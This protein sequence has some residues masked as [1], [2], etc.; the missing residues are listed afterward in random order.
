M[1]GEA[2]DL[3]IKMNY[4]DV[5]EWRRSGAG[6]AVRFARIGRMA[7]AMTTSSALALMSMASGAWAQTV[8]PAIT[9]DGRTQTQIATTTTPGGS[10]IDITTGTVTGAYGV[11]AF[12]SFG[13]AAGQ[14]V[15]MHIPTGAAGTVN[16]VTGGQSAIHGALSSV[17]PGG[18][19]GGEMYFANSSGFLIGP[20]GQVQAGTVGLSTAS[21]AYIDA[22][23]GGSGGGATG[24]GISGSH[25]EALARGEAPL[26]GADIEVQ[27]QVAGQSA[28]RMRAGGDITISGQVSAGSRTSRMAAAV[29]TGVDLQSGGT[30]TISGALTAQNGDDG[31]HIDIRPT[32]D[33]HVT[34]GAVIL[35][36]GE[37]AGHGGE[38]TIFASGAARLDAGA[39]ISAAAAGSGDGGFVEFSATD[40]VSIAGDLQAYSAGGGAGGSI[41]IDPEIVEVI[42]ADFFSLGANIDIL[43]T[44]RITIDPGVT[45]SS[46]ATLPGAGAFADSV[47]HSGNITLTA[48]VVELGAGSML[49]SFANG[50]DASGNP[51]RSGDITLTAIEDD[52]V[53]PQAALNPIGRTGI[54][55]LDATI[56]GGNVTLTATTNKQRTATTAGGVTAYA[57]DVTDSAG[58]SFIDSYIADQVAALENGVQTVLS[59]DEIANAPWA[60]SAQASILLSDTLIFADGTVSIAASAATDMRIAPDT[61]QVNLAFAVTDTQAEVFLQDSAIVAGGAVDVTARTSE[62]VTLRAEAGGNAGQSNTAAAVSYRNARAEVLAQGYWSD[63]SGSLPSAID[64]FYSVIEAG[65]KI[66]IAA[67][68]T[69]DITLEAYSQTNDAGVGNALTFSREISDADVHLGGGYLTDEKALN[70]SATTTYDQFKSVAVT[71]G[72]AGG[73]LPDAFDPTGADTIGVALD[74][75]RDVLSTALGFG[76]VLDAFPVASASTIEWHDV[77]ST[78]VWGDNQYQYLDPHQDVLR[79]LGSAYHNAFDWNSTTSGTSAATFTAETVIDTLQVAAL[80]QLEA[81]ES[82]AGLSSFGYSDWDIDTLAMFGSGSSI[83]ERVDLTLQAHT[84]LPEFDETAID[85]AGDAVLEAAD[86]GTDLALL[87]ASVASPSVATLVGEDWHFLTDLT[88][89]AGRGALALDFAERHID[90]TTT[91][92]MGYEAYPGGN[93][94]ESYTVAALTDGA[95]LSKRGNSAAWADYTTGENHGAG[96]AYSNLDVSAQT[97]ASIEDVNGEMLSVTRARD[98]TLSAKNRLTLSNQVSSY[99][100]ADGS[101]FAGAYAR[102]HYDGLAIAQFDEDNKP[103]FDTFTIRALDDTNLLAATQAGQMAGGVAG[104]GLAWTRVSQ[105]REVAAEITELPDGWGGYASQGAMTRALSMDAD[106]EGL[107]L[108]SADSGAKASDSAGDAGGGA[109]LP[110]FAGEDDGTADTGGEGALSGMGFSITG[111]GD[112]AGISDD[113]T[114]RVTA[115]AE[116]GWAVTTGQFTA[117]NRSVLMTT[118]GAAASGAGLIGLAGGYSSVASTRSTSVALSGGWMGLPGSLVSSSMSIAASDSAVL[119]ALASGRG[120]EGPEFTGIGSV[121]RLVNTAVTSAHGTGGT[122][123]ETYDVTATRAGAAIALAGAYDATGDAEAPDEDGATA[124]EEA[125]KGSGVGLSYTTITSA[126]VTSASATTTGAPD[127]LSIAARNDGYTAGFAFSETAGGA[128][129][130]AGAGM[131]IN[132]TQ[133]TLATGSGIAGASTEIAARNTARV[134]SHI[135]AEGEAERA[136]GGGAIAILNDT[137]DTEAGAASLFG[138]AGDAIT[139]TARATGTS[140]QYLRAGA[141]ADGGLAGELSVARLHADWR[142]AAIGTAVSGAAD[143]LDISAQEAG[144]LENRQGGMV[145][146]EGGAG[147]IGWSETL[148]ESDVAAS[149]SGADIAADTVDVAALS[150]SEITTKAV[151]SGDAKAGGSGVVALSKYLGST[152][153]EVAGGAITADA[154]TVTAHD[155]TWRE[156]VANAAATAETVGAA[157]AIGAD[158]YQR[159][160]SA[161]ISSSQLTLGDDGLTLAATSDTRAAMVSLGRVMDGGQIGFAGVVT[162]LKDDRDVRATLSGGSLATTGGLDVTASRNDMALMLQGT[163]ASST[164]GAG[165][166]A[167]FASFGGRTEARVDQPDVL[168]IAGDFN[169]FAGNGTQ[170]ISLGFGLGSATTGG[171]IGSFADLDM[172]HLANDAAISD[173]SER[174]DYARE[175]AG[176]AKGDIALTLATAGSEAGS[177]AA[178]N[179]FDASGAV[180]LAEADLTGTTATIGV[181]MDIHAYDGR[182]G[183]AIAGQFQAGYLGQNIAAVDKVFDVDELNATGFELT[184]RGSELADESAPEDSAGVDTDGTESEGL[185]DYAEATEDEADPSVTGGGTGGLT[186]GASVAWTRVGGEVAASL[187]MGTVAG[188]GTLDVTGDLDVRTTTAA[189]AGAFSFGAQSSDAALGAGGAFARQ[190]QLATAEISG[191]VITAEDVRVEAINT[192][193]ATTIAGLATKG[194]SAAFGAVLTV[195]D[196]DAET[197]AAIDGATIT[198]G[199]LE[200]EARDVSRGLS[201]GLAGGGAS[202]TAVNMSIAAMSSRAVVGASVHGGAEIDA[203][204]LQIRAERDQAVNALLVQATG[205][206]NIAAGAT[207][208]SVKLAGANEA[209]LADAA[210]DVADDARVLAETAGEI[211]ALSIGAAVGGSGGVSGSLALVAKEDATLAEIADSTVVAGDAVLVQA[212]NTGLIGGLAGGD[213][214]LFGLLSGGQLNLAGGSSFGIGVSVG[215]TKSASQTIARIS[216]DS[217]ITAAATGSGV[218][219]AVRYDSSGYDDRTERT[220]DGIAVIADNDSAIDILAVSAAAGSVAATVQ[221]PVVITEDVVTAEVDGGAGRAALASE[222]EINVFAANDTALSLTSLVAAAAGSGAGGADIEA[223][224]LSKQTT[225]AIR[226]ADVDGGDDIAVTAVAPDQMTTLSGALAAGGGAGVSGIV[227]VARSTSRTEALAQD[228]DLVADNDIS[229]LAKA[230]RSLHQTALN[231]AFGGSAGVGAA[232]LVLSAEDY[233]RAEALDGTIGANVLFDAAEA[234]SIEAESV[235]TATSFV[236]A[237][238]IGGAAGISGSILVADFDQTVIARAG[239]RASSGAR[240]GSLAINATQRID[241]TATVGNVAGGTVGI[242]AS[243]LAVSGS[244]TVLAG[245]GDHTDFETR[246]AATIAASGVRDFAGVSVAAGGGAFSLQGSVTSLAFGMDGESEQSGEHMA[247]LNGD[248]ASGE[249]YEVDGHSVSNGDGEFDGIL[250]QT[251]AM[252]AASID[253]GLRSDE[254]RAHLGEDA[255]LVA[256]TDLSVSATEEG[257]QFAISGAAGGGIVSITGGVTHVRAGTTVGVEIEDGA[258]LDAGGLFE[259][260]IEITGRSDVNLGSTDARGKL[261]DPNGDYDGLTGPTAFAASGGLVG[262]AGAVVDVRAERSVDVSIGDGAL[263]GGAETDIDIRAEELGDIKTTAVSAAGGFVAIGGTFAT[264]KNSSAVKIALSD[265]VL[266]GDAVNV[267]IA[268]TGAVRATAVGVTGG[269]VGTSAVDVAAHDASLAQIDLGSAFISATDLTVRASTDANVVAIGTGVSVGLGAIGAVFSNVDREARAEVMGNGVL[270]LADTVDILAIDAASEAAGDGALIK[271]KTVSTAGGGI[272]VGGASSVLDNRSV[273]QLDLIFDGLVAD[274]AA[275]RAVT[276]ST[277]DAISTGVTLGSVAGG[278]NLVDVTSASTANTLVTFDN[279]NGQSDASG[280]GGGAVIAGDLTVAA[281]GQSEIEMDTRSGTGG[282]FTAQAAYAGLSMTP[283]T[284]VALTGPDAVTVGETARIGAERVISFAN[285]GDSLQATLAG[286]GATWLHN[287]IE[288][289]IDA[290]LDAPLEAAQVE[291]TALTEIEKTED[292][293]SGQIGAVGLATANGLWSDTEITNDA[294]I[295]IN[296]GAAILQG[297]VAPDP[298][299]PGVLIAITNVYDIADSV[300]IDTGGGVAVPAALSHVSIDTVASEIEF[301]GGDV[302]ADGDIEAR[303]S[304]FVDVAN[305][306]YVNVYGLAGV[307]YAEAISEYEGAQVID[308]NNGSHL[309]SSTGDVRLGAGDNA[310]AL[311]SE[312][313]EWNASALPILVNPVARATSDQDANI[314]VGAGASILAAQDVILDASLGSTDIY[315]YG[316]ASDLVREGA[317]AVTNFFG[318]LVGAEE[319]TLDIEV[320]TTSDYQRG[321]TEVGGDVTAG[322]YYQ[323]RLHIDGNG[324]VTLLDDGIEPLFLEDV[325]LTDEMEAY[326]AQLE[327][328]LI[329][330]ADDPYVVAKLTAEIN[331]VTDLIEDLG[332]G[333]IDIVHVGDVFASGGNILASGDYLAG[334]GSLTAHGNDILIEVINDGPYVVEIGDIEV[335]YRAGGD[336][337][338]NG[339]TAASNT[340]LNNLATGIAQGKVFD[341]AG[342]GA[343]PAANLT[344]YST[345][346]T[347]ATPTINIAN[348]FVDQSGP[349]G[350]IYIIGDIENYLGRVEV[351]TLDGG[352]FILGGSIEAAE[353]DVISGGDLYLSVADDQYVYSLGA[354]ALGT[355]GDYFDDV[356]AGGH[357]FGCIDSSCNPPF[358]YIDPEDSGYI[359][360]GNIY[361]Y[362]ANALN[363]TGRVESGT[364]DY[365]LIIDEAFDSVLDLALNTSGYFTDDVP[366]VFDPNLSYSLG[367]EVTTGGTQLVTGNVSLRYDIDNER[368]IVDPV[369][370]KGGYIELVGKVVSTGGGEISAAHGYAHI[371]VDS[372]SELPLVFTG[373]STGFG[374]GAAGTIKITDLGQETTS[375]FLTT[376]FQKNADG[377]VTKTTV[378]GAAGPLGLP[379]ILTTQYGAGEDVAYEVDDDWRVSIYDGAM[380]TELRSDIEVQAN[381]AGAWQTVSQSSDTSELSRDEVFYSDYAKGSDPGLDYYY[382]LMDQLVGGSY[383]ADMQAADYYFLAPRWNG[384]VNEQLLASTQGAWVYS[385][386]GLTRSRTDTETY[387]VPEVAIHA[388]AAGHD[389]DIDFH[390]HDTGAL[391]VAALGDVVFD[392]L[393]YN[394]SGATTFASEAGDVITTGADILLETNRL[395]IEAAGDVRADATYMTGSGGGYGGLRDGSLGSGFGGLDLGSGLTSLVNTGPLTAMQIDLAEGKSLTVTAGG[396]V[397]LAEVDGDMEIN[398]IEAGGDVKLTAAGSMLRHA[399]AADGSHILGQELT[400]SAQSGSI[401]ALDSPLG[402]A[403][404]RLTA[405]AGFDISLFQMLGDIHVNTVNAGAGDV[406]LVA[407]DGAIVDDNAVTLVDRREEAG[408]LE[409]LWDALGLRGD[410]YADGSAN[411]RTEDTIAAY[412]ARRTDEYHAYWDTRIAAGDLAAYDPGHVVTYDAAARAAYAEQGIDGAAVDALEALET[413]RYHALHATYGEMNYNPYYVE[414]AGLLTRLQLSSGGVWSTAELE[415]GLRKSLILQATDTESVVELDNITGVNVN[416]AAS[417]NIGEALAD[418]V[419]SKAAPLTLADKQALWTAERADL[420][421]TDTT[422]TVAR[423]E[424]L[425]VTAGGHLT[426]IAGSDVLIGSEA[427]INA[428]VIFGNDSVRLKTSSGIAMA[429]DIEGLI[430][431]R[432]IVLE[433]GD[434]G[435]GELGAPVLVHHIAPLDLPDDHSLVARSSGHVRIAAPLS[436]IH[437]DEIYSESAVVLTAAGA[438][439]DANENEF[440]NIL[441]TDIVLIAGDEIGA[442]GDAL[443]LSFSGDAPHLSA[444]AQLGDLNITVAEGDVYAGAI[445]SIEGGALIALGNGDLV[446]TGLSDPA[447]AALFTEDHS[448]VT[449]AREGVGAF[450]SLMGDGLAG[451]YGT[452]PSVTP[453]LPVELFGLAGLADFDALGGFGSLGLNAG[454]AG[455]SAHFSELVGSIGQVGLGSVELGA[456]TSADPFALVP[457]LSAGEALIV[458]V[459]GAIEGRAGNALDMAA[460]GAAILSSSADIGAPGEYLITHFEA[461]GQTDTVLLGVSQIPG[462]GDP[463]SAYIANIGDVSLAGIALDDSESD[464]RLLNFGDVDF[465]L[466]G[467]FTAGRMAIAALNAPGALTNADVLISEPVTFTGERLLLMAEG[468]V[469]LSGTGTAAFD[470]DAMILARRIE[471]DA[472][473]A[474]APLTVTAGHDLSIFAE[475][476]IALGDVDARDARLRLSVAQLGMIEA[477]TLDASVLDLS[478]AFGDIHSEALIADH[479]T[480][481]AFGSLHPTV[482]D[483]NQSGVI[484]ALALGDDVEA[485]TLLADP[486]LATLDVHGVFGVKLDVEGAARFDTLST[487]QWGIGLDVSSDA[488]LAFDAVSSG[489]TPV[490]LQGDALALLGDVDSAGGDVTLLATGEITQAEGATIRAGAGTLTFTGGALNVPAASGLAIEAGAVLA[491]V[492][493]GDLRLSTPGDITVLGLASGTDGLVELIATGA[494]SLSGEVASAGGDVILTAM[495]G[496]ISGAGDITA[497]TAYLHAFNGTIGLPDAPLALGA[498]GVERWAI[499]ASEGVGIAF[500]GAGVAGVNADYILS[501]TGGVFLEAD[502]A[503]AIDLL[504]MARLGQ[505]TAPSYTAA[506]IGSDLPQA[507]LPG[508]DPLALYPGSYRD[509]TVAAPATR[510]GS[511]LNPRAVRALLDRGGRLGRRAL[512]RMMDQGLPGGGRRGVFARLFGEEEDDEEEALL[513]GGEP[514]GED[515]S[516]DTG[517]EGADNEL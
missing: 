514:E 107:V 329:D 212:R 7:V 444:I 195:N 509:M 436:D 156:T 237:G 327:A 151:R 257:N 67:T 439:R 287:R 57:G 347:E 324:V 61:Q 260:A 283:V 11:N 65:G 364:T 432:D 23:L 328:D 462:L 378:G 499:G 238:A 384:A 471:G 163:E 46:R 22:A 55:A 190:A 99:G 330:F 298:T 383:S 325:D 172:G 129:G 240:A 403:S 113:T 39:V 210:V 209:I 264:A 411:T 122:N 77:D 82:G 415:L 278:A 166:G 8:T 81:A 437:V 369:I 498:G 192:S 380:V 144:R 389:I 269:V 21:A 137:R 395:T 351:S 373:L 173:P 300:K 108:A 222:D 467:E 101:G 64:S 233:V 251:L 119:R 408:E 409:A 430:T 390:G 89:A 70:V 223:I 321:G 315:A 86:I 491:S 217:D 200:V 304:S 434:G 263:I 140:S 457:V 316:K 500:A 394:R 207:L 333:A 320:G 202:S 502:G 180:I 275:L 100:N 406:S 274:E 259:G 226:R 281:I 181:A 297:G 271:S 102:L 71:Y 421:Q 127:A 323:Q 93:G 216:G 289:D 203:N 158:N 15:N 3:M 9:T 123:F 468:D 208:A 219:G 397:A 218:L 12:G 513:L 302:V 399:I 501:E 488:L 443:E 229:L 312:L 361:L 16:L 280:I 276:N 145:D 497:Q 204:S 154:L 367:N 97:R 92:A 24:S 106:A 277:I 213:E 393:V 248:L 375:G 177:D 63:W 35:A 215:V 133:T 31:G 87:P 142:T 196:M 76:G 452:V 47:N 243:I 481:D 484:H 294:R 404:D 511:F 138:A 18:A 354:A 174:G 480:I 27:G 130:L 41:F 318:S 234:I 198:T 261:D 483:V 114:T 307:P 74:G 374:E 155:D 171:G 445:G 206:G 413:E 400:L 85:E 241:Q 14:S 194:N 407:L 58:I 319:V 164:A 246:G 51:F 267:D 247:E 109:A 5:L 60:L 477:G 239:D 273:A 45:L 211:G 381:I 44:E 469:E 136:S 88:L 412:E 30:T 299:A 244:S 10:I 313:R 176:L 466:G 508:T 121:A 235:T 356:E 398:R 258:F 131:L 348:R 199:G 132:S 188:I 410:D 419:I 446:L 284:S 424:D 449:G 292:G 201:F 372:A 504:G 464:F 344:L 517:G 149:L 371:D 118:G 227:Q 475:H 308:L 478:T 182:S 111:A 69:K 423:Y 286:F 388:L 50:T 4:L 349:S 1:C 170:A 189:R 96:G 377:T 433:A 485:V 368:L 317:E 459:N 279:H 38:I 224:T 353:V 505:V 382:D 450:N 168:D 253:D 470:T 335:A 431:G 236:G 19:V 285:E 396:D 516:G 422:I 95:L 515:G 26:S 197:I 160:T 461:P 25:I 56:L 220:Y 494:L 79:Y 460:G 416:L 376:T 456:D 463:I 331:R 309:T 28:V 489:G 379:I 414:S 141:T 167:G 193:S 126:E 228:A 91:A 255:R 161:E 486:D 20:G 420:S 125:A 80:T 184:Y 482:L 454:S 417:D 429:S 291:I 332:A 75:A 242:G 68:M 472:C 435:I 110:D 322:A 474:C 128:L 272:A 147:A 232:V 339:V 205:A 338:L 479:L 256:G 426:A 360:G 385:P 495:N 493:A 490:Q 250:A 37:G 83:G 336:V 428:G 40:L 120:G 270:V 405:E 152:S 231:A 185:E 139:V 296:G 268:R 225:A 363:I 402:I 32:G 337:R 453:N 387:L 36:T 341:Y 43:A 178:S 293:Y 150:D 366:I 249:A 103:I 262:G 48:P 17:L 345:A 451:R 492:A 175:S 78:L 440:D 183:H 245:L 290:T 352:I 54:Y 282:G 66:D 340:V 346:N 507:T 116:T 72:A 458:L 418:L 34:S 134:K 73:A 143:S 98:L 306:S 115:N 391:N 124:E 392:G 266:I 365:E 117:D 441:A 510:G 326:L 148:Y 59:A 438:I 401:G 265:A 342:H 310:V 465:G 90:I 112:Y 305:E 191:G 487:G 442:T 358:S 135:G 52:T 503:I 425:D 169:V 62:L 105:S 159:D 506:Q 254:I 334:D 53:D 386:D 104:I 33:A 370:A 314:Y 295:E 186:L 153:A 496:P 359:A 252:R 221:V 357:L 427:R 157:G 230:P 343:L 165:V 146:A 362:S 179:I 311:S 49:L 13:V 6:F 448:P 187:E 512:M 42:S 473:A 84:S 455:V 162:A 476:G 2:W 447:L 214:G 350:A 94:I 29:N 355:Y 303:V 288:A 301:N